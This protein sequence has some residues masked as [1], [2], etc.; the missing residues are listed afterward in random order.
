MTTEE[1]DFTN[2]KMLRK[3]AEELLEKKQNKKGKKIIEADIKKLVHELQVHQ[4]ELEM[5]NEELRQAY[6]TTEQALKKYTM[7]YD[8]SPMGYFTLDQ[9]GVIH[10]L[11]FSG[12]EM[13]HEKRF[14]L[15]NVNI[16]LF[17]YEDS[18]PIFNNF[19]SKVYSSNEK[20][21]CEVMLGYEN[22]QLCYTYIEGI[23]TFE[24]QK[25][26]LSVVDISSLKK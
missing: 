18:K 15:I 24:D 25:C 5:Q 23:V 14:S 26:L 19:L 7:L 10:D 16:K 21:S 4:I 22:N 6:E 2:A 9:D 11:N 1:L 12:A 3:K 20:E 17:I 13:L 8:Y